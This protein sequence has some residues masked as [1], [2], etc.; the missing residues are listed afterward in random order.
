MAAR[1]CYEHI[2]LLGFVDGAGLGVGELA[3]VVGGEV[4]GGGGTAAV[5]GVAFHIFLQNSAAILSSFLFESFISPV[6]RSLGTCC[7]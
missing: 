1:K 7:K 2:W 3:A 6:L 5:V 4:L